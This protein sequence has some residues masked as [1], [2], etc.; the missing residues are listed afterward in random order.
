MPVSRLGRASTSDGQLSGR[1]GQCFAG[2]GLSPSH[3]AIAG[4]GRA[5][6]ESWPLEGPPQPVF[7]SPKDC[8]S[9][10]MHRERA[11]IGRH[12]KKPTIDPAHASNYTRSGLE[13]LLLVGGSDRIWIAKR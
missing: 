4:A 13:V 9:L 2:A 7:R 12:F 11:G 8:L 6:A 5:T 3:V 1:S 10:V